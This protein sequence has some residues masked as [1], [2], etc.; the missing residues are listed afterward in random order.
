[1]YANTVPMN[2]IP[3]ILHYL[4]AGP[5]STLAE[6]RRLHPRWDLIEWERDSCVAMMHTFYAET[7]PLYH[8]SSESQRIRLLRLLLLHR[9][10]GISIDTRLRP[11]RCLHSWRMSK[12]LLFS[13]D[14][15]WIAAPPKCEE[16]IAYLRSLEPASRLG[17]WYTTERDRRVWYELTDRPPISRSRFLLGLVPPP[18]PI[19]KAKRYMRY[20]AI[21]LLF[22][23][24][25]FKNKPVFKVF[26]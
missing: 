25:K 11:L 19:R 26:R 7:V 24:W 15:S 9:Y 12:R 23:A 22:L 14:L 3:P 4:P 1:M 2:D 18:D 5:D 20:L 17:E 13:E 21:V 6:W 8:S 16:I 10:G